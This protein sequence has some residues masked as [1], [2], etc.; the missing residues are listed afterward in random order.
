MASIGAAEQLAFVA[1]ALSALTE[2]KIVTKIEYDRI[3]NEV[4][5]GKNK[6]YACVGQV[7][8]VE[9]IKKTY[10]KT[11]ELVAERHFSQADD[12]EISRVFGPEMVTKLAMRKSL[13]STQKYKQPRE[14]DTIMKPSTDVTISNTTKIRKSQ[15]FRERMSSNGNFP[16]LRKEEK[17][18]KFKSNSGECKQKPLLLTPKMLP[19]AGI[20]Y[21]PSIKPTT[22]ITRTLSDDSIHIEAT[23][24]REI[25]SGGSPL[26]DEGAISDVEVRKPLSR[27]I[28]KKLQIKNSAKKNKSSEDIHEG[29]LDTSAIS[30]TDEIEKRKHGRYYKMWEDKDIDTDSDENDPSS[31]EFVIETGQKEKER[32]KAGRARHISRKEDKLF[33]SSSSEED[34][35]YRGGSDTEL[36]TGKVTM[37]Q[38]LF[39][40]EKTVDL[41]VIL[42]SGDTIIVEMESTN[43]LVNNV[44]YKIKEKTGISTTEQVLQFGGNLLEDNK[45]LHEYKI[46]ANSTIHLSIKAKGG[47]KTEVSYIDNTYLDPRYD[48]DFRKVKDGSTKFMRGGYQYYRPCGWNRYAIKVLGKYENAVWLGKT[49]KHEKDVCEEWAVSYHGTKFNVLDKI[50]RGKYIVGPRE[51]HG[52]GVYSSP[53]INVAESFATAFKYKRRRYVAVFQNRVNPK[54]VRIV[55]GKYG[56]YWICADPVNIRPYGLCVKKVK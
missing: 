23:R 10:A 5:S 18:H 55:E 28:W 39:R 49:G 2:K 24:Q 48:Y 41:L 29:F 25:A 17:G 33:D 32:K 45:A 47:A 38:R 9:E 44:K 43:N 35:V 50:A 8:V 40:T 34:D 19:P 27:R 30:E 15:S 20:G 52:R 37:P 1:A 42:P 51:L 21:N 53:L 36:L 11:A 12:A 16:F 46:R 13:Y 22:K 7:N 56:Q 6:E 3:D 54:G 4:K 31:D 14:Q 26:E